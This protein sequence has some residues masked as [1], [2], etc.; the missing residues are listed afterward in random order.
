MLCVNS[1]AMSVIFFQNVKNFI[2][3]SKMKKKL[4]KIFFFLDIIASEDVVL[5]C[6]Y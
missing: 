1:L 3:I 2:D 5:N 6:L 4:Q